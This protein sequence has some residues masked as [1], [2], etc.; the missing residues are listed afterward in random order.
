MTRAAS[1]RKK[2]P[3]TAVASACTLSCPRSR[4]CVYARVCARVY[5]LVRAR[6]CVCTRGAPSESP[7]RAHAAAAAASRESPVFV[8]RSLLLRHSTEKR[9]AERRGGGQR[10]RRREPADRRAGGA[11]GRAAERPIK[12]ESARTR[13]GGGVR[14]GG[15][16]PRRGGE[17]GRR[18]NSR[19]IRHGRRAAVRVCACTSCVRVRAS[20]VR[21]GGA[22]PPSDPFPFAAR[23]YPR[24]HLPDRGAT[25]RPRGNRRNAP[26]RRGDHRAPRRVAL[27]FFFFFRRGK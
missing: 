24:R 1:A 14:V 25:T 9:V 6:V 7:A 12:T 15:G 16:W 20:C 23:T 8:A 17:R 21:A 22:R 19:S 27:F 18:A 2:P 4:V 3:T 26:C 10:A 5:T 13:R 11:G